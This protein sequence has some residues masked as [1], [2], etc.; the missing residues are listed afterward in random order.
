VGDP[1]LMLARSFGGAAHDYELGRP[2]WPAEVVDV[3][4]LDAGATVLD[5]A[6]G[7]GKLTR[8]L[9]RRFAHVIAIEPDDGMRALIPPG[10]DVRAGTAEALPLEDAS[11]DGAFVAEAFHWFDYERAL[12]ELA[13][14]LKPGAPLVL[15]WNLPP[16]GEGGWEPDLP[17]AANDAL[18]RRFRKS[19]GP[20]GLSLVKSGVWREPFASAPFGPLVEHGFS[21]EHVTDRE[22]VIAYWLSVSSIA[23][24]PEDERD[25]LAEELRALVPETEYRFRCHA[26]IQMTRRL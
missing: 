2:E 22:G 6:A 9:A 20:P 14:V 1:K 12:A 8:V 7:T 24:M 11:V 4:A 19:V 16:E 10:A 5:L 18:T 3:A 26:H 21:F 17:Q 15:V 13:R 23:A 25:E